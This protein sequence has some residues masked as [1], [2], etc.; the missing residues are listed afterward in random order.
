MKNNDFKHS[1]TNFRWPHYLYS[2]R[3]VHENYWLR[4]ASNILFYPSC[5]DCIAYKWSW[6]PGVFI[7]SM[8]ACDSENKYR[9]SRWAILFTIE[10]QY[11]QCVDSNFY[12]CSLLEHSDIEVSTFDMC[13]QCDIIM[14]AHLDTHKWKQF[15]LWFGKKSFGDSKLQTWFRDLHVGNIPFTAESPLLPHIK[16]WRNQF[17]CK[18]T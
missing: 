16:L 1:D 4:R 7:H 17:C 12:K 11:I 8:C 6:A 2:C 9:Y 15:G 5:Y 14:W 3:H 10:G 18:E 13:E